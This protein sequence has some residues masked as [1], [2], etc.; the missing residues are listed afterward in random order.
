M[1]R[2]LEKSLLFDFYGELLTQHQKKVYGEYIQND[3]S[4]SE[5]A[6]LLGISRQGVH[7]L[8]RRCEKILSDYESRLHLVEN[9]QQVKKTVAAIHSCAREIED[10]EDRTLIHEK[11]AEIAELSSSILEEY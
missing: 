8:I 10:C 4:Y 9:F 1:D 11:I 5:L 7:D 2:I 6:E 3:L